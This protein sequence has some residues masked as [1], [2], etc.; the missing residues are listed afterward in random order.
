VRPF[1]ACLRRV[2]GRLLRARL[3]TTGYPHD[4][5]SVSFL[6]YPYGVCA[7][8]VID[9]LPADNPITTYQQAYK[10]TLTL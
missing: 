10:Q 2:S 6:F 4:G 3:R 8:D 7:G 5:G 1:R 9:R